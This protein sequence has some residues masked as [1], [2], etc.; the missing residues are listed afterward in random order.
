MPSL[1]Y[2]PVST[3]EADLLLG[4]HSPYTRS[5]SNPSVAAA[6]QTPNAFGYPQQQGNM[7]NIQQQQYF[8]NQGQNFNNM[9]IET[10]DIDMSGQQLNFNF[11]GGDMIPWLE[12]L[13]QDVLNY[14]GDPQ[15]D[16]E[17][18]LQPG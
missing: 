1:P 16:A 13:P 10:Q 2:D 7:P 5:V 17:G 4:L 8:D 6:G 9:F 18:F 12:Y 3:A 11:P 15:A 14:F